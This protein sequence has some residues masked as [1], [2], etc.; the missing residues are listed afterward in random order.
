MGSYFAT[1]VSINNQLSDYLDFS[2]FEII[3]S[4]HDY[5][6]LF[7]D[8]GLLK[9]KYNH[10]NLIDSTTN[11]HESH[12]YFKYKIR[13]KNTLF[14]GEIIENEAVL[15]FDYEEGQKTNTVFNTIK[16]KNNQNHSLKV[17]PNPAIDRTN[18]S[19]KSEHLCL[20]TPL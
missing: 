16:H 4:S 1:H 15:I 13:P 10:I 6:Y 3:S 19:L 20:K 7:N 11:E 18:I 5:N 8:E 12:G 17:F 14:G 2:S 9:I